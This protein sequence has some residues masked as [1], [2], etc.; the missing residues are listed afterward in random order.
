ME[1]SA[2]MV[3][4]IDYSAFRRLKDERI[5]RHLLGHLLR[6]VLLDLLLQHRGNFTLQLQMQL[7]A[8]D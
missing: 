5:F 3:R 4:H 2:A 8:Q 6:L 7:F 1:N